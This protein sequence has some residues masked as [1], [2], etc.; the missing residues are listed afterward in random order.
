M[1]SVE[2]RSIGDHYGEMGD[3]FPVAIPRSVFLKTGSALETVVDLSMPSVGPKWNHVRTYDSINGTNTCQGQ[4]WYHS[5][6]PK[7]IEDASQNINIWF[8]SYRDLGFDYDSG[9]Q[10]YSVRDHEGYALT[11]D[12]VNDRFVL[13]SDSKDQWRFRILITRQLRSG[14]S[15]MKSVMFMEIPSPYPTPPASSLRWMMRVA[16]A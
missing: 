16:T 12:A 15:Y 7:I 9:T 8:N 13:E 5:L 11:H 14:E 10:T 1:P 4:M 2:Y 6:M 3:D